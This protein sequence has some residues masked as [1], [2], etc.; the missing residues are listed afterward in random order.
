LT[1]VYRLLREPFSL[2]PFDDE[3]SFRYGG[4]WS[5]PGTRVVY[6]PEH[7]SLAMLEYLVHLD[8][9]QPPIDIMLAKADVPED[10]SRIEP[11]PD[12][13]PIPFSSP[14]Q[15]VRRNANFRVPATDA[16]RCRFAGLFLAGRS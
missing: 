16:I 3:G 5:R 2:T 14:V 10:V 4:R 8:A 13:G 11:D 6:T 15:E 1:S 12:I 9:D 7:L